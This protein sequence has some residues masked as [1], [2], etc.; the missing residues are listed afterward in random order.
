MTC[1][2]LRVSRGITTV[3]SFFVAVRA[4]DGKMFRL[5]RFMEPITETL[6]HVGTQERQK[7]F[8]GPQEG[9]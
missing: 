2:G 7:R 3:T 5:L 9:S 6:R 4:G 1:C 8:P